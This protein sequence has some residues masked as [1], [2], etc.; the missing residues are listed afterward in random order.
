MLLN[1]LFSIADE[2]PIDIL[3]TGEKISSVF[4]G[5]STYTNSSG[6]PAINFGNAIV[7]PGIIN[8]HDHL[9]FNSFPQL[10]NRI[11]NNYV[12]WGEDI[13][14]QNKN[15]INS[16]LKIPEELRIQW[17]IYKNLLN[18][19]TTVVNHGPKLN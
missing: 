10:G 7:F 15:V 19:I 4:N 17:G 2:K 6:E 13:H 8:S 14:H 18:G 9:D 11:Y 3:I 16:V 1:N 5:G 12:E